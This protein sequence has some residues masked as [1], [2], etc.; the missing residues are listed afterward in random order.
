M[1]SP[2][3]TL[4][5]F[6]L[7]L[8]VSPILKAAFVER[9]SPETGERQ[10][11]MCPVLPD[12]PA[13]TDYF[14]DYEGERVYLC[15][16]SCEAKFLQ[17]PQKYLDNKVAAISYASIVDITG[18]EHQEEEEHHKEG[19]WSYVG[20]MHVLLVHFPIALLVTAGLMELAAY[21]YNRP[22]FSSWAGVSVLLASVFAVLAAATGMIW[23]GELTQDTLLEYHRWFGVAT[24]FMMIFAS[25]MY[26]KSASPCRL[27][28]YR[29]W[30][31]GA[32][33]G[34]IVTGHFGGSMVFGVDFLF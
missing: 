23:V 6:L 21:L 31:V 10:C 24:T 32:I 29:I 16:K 20:K 30:L 8:A 11:L 18:E 14:V 19:L 15:C 27:K 26:W 3:R 9:T 1:K 17:D 22:D 7:T 33:A 13:R 4:V 12:K 34:V 2:C 5:L 25:Y 28:W